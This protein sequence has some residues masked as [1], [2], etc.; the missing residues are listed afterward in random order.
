MKRTVILLASVMLG[1][2]TL[3]GVAVALPAETPDNTPMVDGP[4]RGIAEVGTKVWVVG[5]FSRVNQRDGSLVDNVRNVAVFDSNTGQYVDIAPM[6][7]GPTAVVRDVAVYNDDVVIAGS[8]G[9]PSGSQKNLVQ[10]DGGT[11]AVV[12]WYNAPALQ[13]VLAAPGLGRVYGG[14]L[15]LS[16][17]DPA[18]GGRLWTRAT[19]S[20][21]PSI[22]SH[23]TVAGYRDL[24][25]DGRTIWAACACDTVA[26]NP[27]KAL[28][29]LDAEGAHDTTWRT[30]AGVAGFGISVAQTDGT[31]Y[32][33]AGGNDF[34]AEY[35][36]VG[37]GRRGWIRDT[38]GST[39]AVEVM[40]GRL[41]AGGHFWEVGDQGGD[42]CG[43]RSSNNAAT[44]DPND[45][46]QTRYG[47]AAYSF[48]GAL[49]PNWSPTVAGRYNLIWALQPSGTR[50]H[51]GGDFTSVN[52]IRQTFYGRLS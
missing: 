46:C 2:L 4:V 44:L 9:G 32:L 34:L 11:G 49:D 22:R 26:G 42:R 8:F 13:S 39:Q 10:L 41:V 14:G 52:A 35:P 36:K 20:I 23:A 51:I 37:N 50:L 6:L 30:E 47:L 21:D 19:T 28:V 40:E 45:E 18:T 38:S 27:A 12:R 7:G 48:G 1:I 29:K 17:F 33:G 31:L 3:A 43:F 25:L 15:G 24:E 5:N 16:A